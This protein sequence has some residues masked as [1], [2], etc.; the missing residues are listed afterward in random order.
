MTYADPPLTI[1]DEAAV[2]AAP[3]QEEP[4]EFAFV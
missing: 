2:A 4:Y 3:L 1:I